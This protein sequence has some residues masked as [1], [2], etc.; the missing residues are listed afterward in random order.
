MRAY[1]AVESCCIALRPG[2]FQE[3]PVFSFLAFYRSAKHV[4]FINHRISLGHPVMMAW[5][6]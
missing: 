1:L 3:I 4:S 5:Q 6:P 2:P